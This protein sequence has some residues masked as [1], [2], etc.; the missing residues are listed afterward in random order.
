M[1]MFNKFSIFRILN[2]LDEINYLSQLLLDLY[3]QMG[4]SS[5]L[6]IESEFCISMRKVIL[7]RSS[8]QRSFLKKVLLKISQNSQENT[9]ARVS[10]LI[11]LLKRD[12]IKKRPWNRWFPVNFVKFLRSPFLQ[13]KSGRLLLSVDITHTRNVKSLSRDKW[14][15]ISRNVSW[16]L[17]S[18]Q[19]RVQTSQ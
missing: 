14:T 9:C 17:P 3:V 6:E 13:N 11:T 18:Q 15:Q 8:H 12:F 2:K 7:Y 4:S 1:I 5:T 16:L 19:L 10:F